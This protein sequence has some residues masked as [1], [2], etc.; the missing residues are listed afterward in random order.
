MDIDMTDEEATTRLVEHVREHGVATAPLIFP[1]NEDDVVALQWQN[2]DRI[3][4]A[5]VF[6]SGDEEADFTWSEPGR[7]YSETPIAFRISDGLPDEA[8]AVIRRLGFVETG[9]N[10]EKA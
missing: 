7:F 6:T 5:V 1:R 4:F 10:T 3:G 9:M 2:E 8:L